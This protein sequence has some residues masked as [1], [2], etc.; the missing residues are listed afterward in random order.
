MK[1]TKI[2]AILVL[3]LALIVCVAEVSKAAPLGTAFTYQGHLYDANYVADG[4]YDFA[5]KLFDD[6]NDPCSGN[7]LGSDVNKPDVDVI[8]GYFTVELDFGGV[9]DGNAVWLEI[10]VR[11]GEMN[12]PNA[13]PPLSPRQ[14][15]TPTPYALHTRWFLVDEA[16]NNVFAGEGAGASNTTGSS[17]SAVGDYALYSN[18]TGTWNSAVGNDA[19]WFNTTGWSNS[20]VGNGALYSNTTGYRNSAMGYRA[21]Y[22]NIDGYDNSAMG[23]Y[24]LYAN[25]TGLRNSAVGN[26]AL[27]SNTTGSENSAMGYQALRNNT[28]GGYNSAMGNRANYYNG[29]GS[30]NTIIGY[31]AGRGTALHNKSGNVFIGYRAGYYETG[32]NKLY[33]ANSN[34]DANTIIYGDFDTGNVGIGTTS[35][36]AKLSVGG[37]GIANTGVYGEGSTYGVQGQHA[38]TGNYGRLGTITDGAFGQSSKPGG[39]GVAGVN[40]GVGN[41]V[42]GRSDNGKGVHGVSSDG[43]AGYFNGDVTL[44]KPSGQGGGELVLRTETYNELGRYRIRF[45]NNAL[46]V[47]AGDDT[48][49]QQFSF[50]SRW[51]GNRE[52]D[53]RLSVHG[54]A[55]GSW[56]TYI[57]LTHDGN[58]GL[59]ETDVGDIVLSPAG[60]VGIGTTNPLSKLSVGGDGTSATGVYAT[61]SYAVWGNGSLTGVYGYCSD[62]SGTN[63]GV[64]ARAGSTSSNNAYALRSRVDRS[65]SG[66]Y[67]SGYFEDNDTGGTYNG[68]YADERTGGAIDI[69][70]YILD[71]KG[72]TEA[73]DVLAADPDND[74]SVIKS[75]IPYDSTVVGIVSTQ[76]HLLMGMELVMDE[77]TGEMYEDVS[78]TKLALAGQVP[79][80]VTDENGPIERGDLLTTSSKSGYAMKWT[81]LDVNQ[82]EDFDELK[83]ILAENERRR[84]AVVGKALGNLDSGDG[85]IVAL[86]NLQ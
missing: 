78:A 81:L 54:K 60:N 1:T 62:G 15:V 38:S 45:E 25:T 64:Y 6:S 31:E 29:E 58:D 18:T 46:G 39:S 42:Y 22:S 24:A 35:P 12:D 48:Q 57:A 44:T 32:D 69:A 43:L 82:A 49:N 73:G 5:F 50:V 40:T 41:G 13:Y 34:S 2:L 70:E 80:K 76:P 8:D 9:F 65:G 63:Y 36:E 26:Y 47:F 19:L 61:A 14:E 3:A 10:G 7:Q 21:L 75:S 66:T 11:P 4:L 86:V 77:E 28:T 16:L 74:E 55:S 37:D 52:Y 84:N 79:V 83:S 71:T 53:A 30:R 17:N 23:Y 51:G 20:A 67:W 85:K 59:I 33:I 27:R 68:L 72:D 56:G